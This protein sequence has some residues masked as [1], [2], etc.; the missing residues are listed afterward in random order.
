MNAAQIAGQLT[1]TGA[2]LDG[3]GTTALNAQGASITQSL[4]LGSV[5]ATGTIDVAVGQIGGQFDCT[6]AVLKGGKDEKGQRQPALHAQ[7]LSIGENLHLRNVVAT[8][9]VALNRALIEGQFDCTGAALDGQGGEALEAQGLRV[10]QGFF[11]RDLRSVTGGIDLTAA[12]IGDLVDDPACW[13]T[14]D[15]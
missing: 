2:V 9:T 14:S 7:G 6:G 5:V 13:P 15:K 1:C 8:G 12:Q 11:F 3:N 4:F 10:T